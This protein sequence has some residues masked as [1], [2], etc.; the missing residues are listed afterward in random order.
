[1]HV[2]AVLRYG[3]SALAAA[4]AALVVVAP[5]TF[6]NTQ[7]LSIIAPQGARPASGKTYGD[8]S[9]AWWQLMM[10]IPVESN[11]TFDST[12]ANCSGGNTAGVFFLAGQGTGETVMRSC[13]V[14]TTKPLFF[15]LINVEC[16]NVEAPPFYGATDADR[17]ACARQVADGIGISTLQVVL[18]GVN[19]GNMSR[20][21]AASLPFNF[22]VPL[23]DNI[24]FVDGVT[25]GT[26]ASDGYWVL[27]NPPSRGAHT[28]H[29]EG[30][31]ISGVGAGFSQNVTYN[32]TAQ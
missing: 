10:A 32:L 29:F 30:L 25:S 3:I 23:N 9:A 13:T 22:T 8:W 20:F 7:R 12:G 21:R 19:V 18:D 27:L 6:A 16:S 28:I 26:S 11:P 15:P 1:M 5:A 2:R 17:E 14:P 24:L 4:V 31:V